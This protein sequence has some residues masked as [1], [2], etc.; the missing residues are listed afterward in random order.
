VSPPTNEPV[1]IVVTGAGMVSA[2]GGDVES[3]WAAVLAGARGMGTVSL[4]DA[5]SYKSNIAAEVRGLRSVDEDTWSRTA[6]M[7]LVAARE[8]SLS[9]R[10]AE[11]RLAGLRIGLV[12]GATT[13]GMYET[14]TLLGVL[15]DP[16][17][18]ETTKDEAWR[19]LLSNPI[20][21]TTQWID[22]E[23]GPFTRTRTLSSACSSGAN[24]ILVAASWILLDLVDVVLAGGADGLCRLTQ[25]GFGA[26]SACDPEPCRPFDERRRGLNLGE[27]AGFLVLERESRAK[28]RGVQ[29]RCE[30]AGW[31]VGSEAHH[32]TNPES[33]GSTPARLLTQALAR[34]GLGPA[35]LD[36]VNAHGTA[37][38][39]NDSMESAGLLAALGEHASRVPVSSSKGSLGHTL[40]AAGALEAVLTTL[41]LRD[42]RIP[43]TAGLEQVD[44]KCPLRHVFSAETANVDVA[45]SSSFGFGGM[46]TVLVFAKVG[47]SK[48]HVPQ[49]NDVVITGAAAVTP[50][51][52]AVGDRTHTVLGS[53]LAKSSVDLDPAFFDV[54]RARRLDRLSRL[55][56]VVVERALG[57][58][59]ASRE[60]P[61]GERI[62][63]LLGNAWGNLDASAS[64]MRRVFEKGPRL[65]SPAD[66]PNLVPSAPVGHV[67]I[68]LGLS[69]PSFAL[70]DFA[71]SGE[72]SFLQGAEMVA[73]GE[74]RAICTGGVEEESD[75]VENVLSRVF[76]GP[77]SER[78]VRAEGAGALMLAS[79]SYAAE[80]KLPVLAR[81]LAAIA[82]RTANG[83]STEVLPEPVSRSVVLARSSKI[84]ARLLEG[85]PWAATPVVAAEGATGVHESA[86]AIFLASATSLVASGTYD[87]VLVLGES[88]ANGYLAVLG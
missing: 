64:F 80:R 40:A 79:S 12:V 11:A 3:T 81:V 29:A 88:G 19:K 52:L 61:Y 66:F 14:E 51:G 9:G 20:S 45:A 77:R 36:Y 48:P 5:T 49:R 34:G 57:T 75:I 13:G 6:E 10:L 82:Y 43:P 84:A 24:A 25:A 68:Y 62:G 33:T 83:L 53:S 72:A 55:A 21:S 18:R 38:P 47:R 16:K 4:F 8:A 71:A 35:D 78:P 56:T 50:N 17:E 46:D 39:L 65:A 73:S 27:G 67:S 15:A 42:G 31:A 30:L 60:V 2:V 59:E 22:D 41:T 58:G 87:R 37:T 76:E 54:T 44:P 32:I 63:L 70:V 1:R 85:T 69:G 26:L 28:A 7:G 74:V 86:G 23:L